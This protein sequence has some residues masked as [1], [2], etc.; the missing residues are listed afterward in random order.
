MAALLVRTHSHT[1][2]IHQNDQH[3]EQKGCRSYAEIWTPILCEHCGRYGQCYH[4]HTICQPVIIN[5]ESKL[6]V[7]G[8]H[9]S[10]EDQLRSR[11]PHRQTHWDNP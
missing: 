2:S 1:T 11:E 9:T 4:A 10:T 8:V 5:Q 7:R 6:R 3:E